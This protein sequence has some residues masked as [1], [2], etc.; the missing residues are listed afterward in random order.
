MKRPGRAPTIIALRACREALLIAR[1][2]AYPELKVPPQ[3]PAP[4]W[5]DVDDQWMTWRAAGR[6]LPHAP[7]DPGK[8]QMSRCIQRPRGPSMSFSDWLIVAVVVL[9]NVAAITFVLTVG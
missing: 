2:V 1:D 7:R 6:P 9:F 8:W 3:A 4:L 5:K